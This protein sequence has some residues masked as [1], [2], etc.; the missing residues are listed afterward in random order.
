MHLG[1]PDSNAA[2]LVRVRHTIGSRS[3]C[4]GTHEF[5]FVAEEIEFSLAD[6]TLP[7]EINYLPGGNCSWIRH[8]ID[9]ERDTAF[10][11]EQTGFHK[12]LQLRNGIG[13]VE[14]SRVA[15]QL[16]EIVARVFELVEGNAHAPDVDIRVTSQDF[17]TQ[18]LGPAVKGTVFW[19]KVK[20]GAS[21]SVNPEPSGRDPV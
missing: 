12:L 21:F 6:A 3:L 13:R 20:L 17:L 15:H 11:A 8:I 1:H 4:C 19:R 5:V 10:P 7:Y 2:Y 16:G 14:E 18:R 9:S